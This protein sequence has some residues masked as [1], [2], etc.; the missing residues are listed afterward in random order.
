MCDDWTRMKFKTLTDKIPKSSCVYFLFND[1]ELV[2]IGQTQNLKQRL[3]WNNSVINAN[4]FIGNKPMDSFIFDSVYYLP[5][6]NK[7]EERLRI[8]R[9]YL[10]MYNPKCNWSGIF[11]R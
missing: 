9:E 1:I 2:Y 8:E 4:W 6:V 10:E 5:V 3:Q 7:K 11:Q